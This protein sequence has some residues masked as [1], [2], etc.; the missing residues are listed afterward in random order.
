MLQLLSSLL[1][2]LLLFLLFFLRRRRPPRST[3]FPYTTLFRSH[4]RG[5]LGRHG[6]DGLGPHRR[7]LAI[8]GRRRLPVRERDDI[9]FD[10]NG[11]DGGRREPAVDLGRD[12][13]EPRDPDDRGDNAGRGDRRRPAKR[14]WR[15]TPTNA[16]T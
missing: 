4:R 6:R 12:L 8:D 14:L 7:R 3:L 9:A 1:L 15:P 11:R 10:G 5:A 16:S 13:I 2:R